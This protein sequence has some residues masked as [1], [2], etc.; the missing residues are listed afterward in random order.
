MFERPK[1]ASTLWVAHSKFAPGT[2][3]KAHQHDYYHMYHV[4]QGTVDISINGEV[5]KLQS[6]DTIFACPHVIHDLKNTDT[7][8]ARLYE[9]KFAVFNPFFEQ[10]LHRT[11]PFF[12]ADSMT[13][14]IIHAIAEET[15]LLAQSSYYIISDYLTALLAYITRGTR[16]QGYHDSRIINTQGFSNTSK[17]IVRY[18]EEHYMHSVTLQ[19]IANALSLNKNYLCTVFKNDSNITIIDCLTTI[20]LSKASELISCSDQSLK[21]IAADTGFVNLSHF[22]KTFKKA[23][24]IT[25]GQYRQVFPLSSNLQEVAEQPIEPVGAVIP[26]QTV[27]PSQILPAAKPFWKTEIICQNTENLL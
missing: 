16:R 22:N 24:G 1:K 3:Q 2:G 8:T 9:V 5:F 15:K 4:I 11:D 6:Q 14:S 27:F 19:D 13:L 26:G 17:A 23:Y 18:L 7:E 21:Q 25:P 12:H 10:A 20:R